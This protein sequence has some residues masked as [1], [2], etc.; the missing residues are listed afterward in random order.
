MQLFSYFATTAFLAMPNFSDLAKR[1]II[2]LASVIFV[3]GV[4]VLVHEFG[5]Y[6]VA[7]L[8]GVRVEVFSL[9]FGKRLWGFRRGDTDY[10]LSLLPLGGY[11]KM[12]G[13]NPMEERTGDPGE[14]TSHP[15]WQRFLIAIAGPAM[16][17]V[18]AIVVL[19]GVYMVHD[20][21]P[22]FLSQPAVIGVVESGSPAEK[23]GIKA[24]D[25]I[26]RIQKVKN[27]TWQDVIPEIMISPGQAVELTIQRGEQSFQAQVI[28]ETEGQDRLGYAGW[29]AQ[30]PPLVG[31]VDP[32]LPAAKAGIK[33]GDEILS[34][35]G[36]PV[37][38]MSQFVE[39]LQQS[40]SA[41]IQL[42]VLRE[43][44]ELPFTVTPQLADDGSGTGKTKY[45]IG[46]IP[47]I[48]MIVQKLPFRDAFGKSV[49]TCKGYSSLLFRLVPRLIE[50]K[51]SIRQMSGPVGIMRESGRMAMAGWPSLL[52]FMAMLSVSLAVL[53][54]LP[55]PI[56]DGGLMLM[57]LIEGIIRRDIKVEIK[58]R[59][60]YAAF[61]C[62]ILFAAVITF[63]DV[64][65]SFHG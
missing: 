30:Q 49:D 13:E 41:P 14:F 20:E 22:A 37:A 26:T 47:Q 53:N 3:L 51:N 61:V 57:L 63:F 44:K 33:T 1:G 46:F 4:L 39:L 52:Q 40:K 60:Y 36:K 28:P 58:E 31:E 7:K 56:L 2:S 6:A 16:N 48:R 55:F 43:G 59:L 62:L 10:R 29:G 25:R 64:A 34:F 38:S 18:L 32:D 9:G 65:K 27:P 42:T 23:A 12:S 50:A 8:C 35:N 11:V 45:R 24:G 21:E 54:I 15:R 19:T 5:H 17:I